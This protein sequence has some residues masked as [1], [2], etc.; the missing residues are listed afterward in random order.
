VLINQV[1][2]FFGKYHI[3]DVV[4]YA[5]IAFCV[6][7]HPFLEVSKR[8][9][10]LLCFSKKFLELKLRHEGI[11][12]LGANLTF[13][14]NCLFTWRLFYVHSVRKV[15]DFVFLLLLAIRI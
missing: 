7:A 9:K 11:Q 4:N 5:P 8:Y 13:V 2:E 15:L 12:I 1:E 10:L 6:T 14:D 3:V